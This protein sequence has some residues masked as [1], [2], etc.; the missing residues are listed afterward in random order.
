MNISRTFHFPQPD[1][2]SIK[3]VSELLDRTL[4]GCLITVDPMARNSTRAVFTNDMD[5]NTSAAMHM[6]AVE[7]LEQLHRA[8]VRAEAILFDPPYSPRQMAE[9]YRAA[10]KA[11]T[12]ETTQNGRFYKR[13]REAADRILHVGGIVI[14]AG[15]N[16]ASFGPHYETK[17]VLI[18]SHGGAHNDTL[19]TV[20]I[21][22]KEASK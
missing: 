4:K 3:P 8:N 21:K 11:V 6:D 12:R 13:V 15:W 10:G 9:H 1:T 7:F 22:Q 19:I 20:Q 2:W 18:V 5:P 14:T 17:E 16:T